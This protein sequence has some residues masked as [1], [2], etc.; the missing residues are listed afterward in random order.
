M[1][2]T[3]AQYSSNYRKSGKKGKKSFK[4]QLRSLQKKVLTHEPE[5]KYYCTSQDP[6]DVGQIGY[7]ECVSDMVRGTSSAQRVGDVIMAK[8]LTVRWSMQVADTVNIF[9]LIVARSKGLTTGITTGKFPIGTTPNNQPL[10]CW[11][12]L[13]HN[14]YNILHDQVYVT[15]ADGGDVIAGVMHLNCHNSKIYFDDDVS[16]TNPIDGEYMIFA[17]SD[18]TAAA[19]P[20]FNY[21][22]QLAYTDA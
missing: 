12:D 4:S 10:G 18:S 21:E 1:S 9:R 14:H 19:H 5:V 20:Q 6:I 7:V 17:V 8:S 13:K 22:C 11:T 15:S 16:A 3:K 2:G